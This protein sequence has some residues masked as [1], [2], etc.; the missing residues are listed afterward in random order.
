MSEYN[1]DGW[2]IVKV[3]TPDK[4]IYKVFAAWA[5]GYLHGD[6]WKLNSGI[7]G[8][9]V[10]DKNVKV[11]GYSGSI[12]NLRKECEGRITTYNMCALSGIIDGAGKQPGCKMESISLEDFIKEFC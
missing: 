1:P 5:G 11:T 7:V 10:D 4:V 12:Y 3:T 8:V 2:T 9:L 6:N